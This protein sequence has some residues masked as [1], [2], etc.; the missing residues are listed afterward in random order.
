MLNN[1]FRL[2]YDLI[3]PNSGAGLV[4]Y[5]KPIRFCGLGN[6]NPTNF[7]SNF[8]FSIFDLNPNSIGGGFA[9]VISPDDIS[10]GA[11]GGFLGIPAGSVAL[12]FDTFKD[13][14]FKD[15][16]GNHVGLDINST[17]S[18]HV[19]DLDRV[20]VNL[21]SGELIYSWVE[22]SGSNHQLKVYISNS[23]TKPKSP[24]L[25]VTLDLCHY[26]NEFMF[27]GFSGSTQGSTEVHSVEYWSF[28][29]AFDDPYTELGSNS[30]PPTSPPPI[31]DFMSPPFDPTPF[32]LPPTISTTHTTQTYRKPSKL[33]RWLVGALVGIVVT[34]GISIY[35]KYQNGDKNQYYNISDEFVESAKL[36]FGLSEELFVV[37][38]EESVGSVIG[39]GIP[40][41][42][43]VML[44]P[45]CLRPWELPMARKSNN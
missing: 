27:V 6:P 35:I 5:N 14:E 45:M 10:I 39:I 31:S 25:P 8:S 1:T 21:R 2:T 9:F 41:I 44:G 42:S 43:A 38:D 33:I 34:G 37:D 30:Q 12:E 16:N 23:K 18:L 36:R 22:Y 26:V 3:V 17:V 28:T 20:K 24:V 13:M 19:V 32:S 29:S 40:P 7:D 11:A 4:L 15:V